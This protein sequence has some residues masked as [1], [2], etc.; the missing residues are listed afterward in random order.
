MTII[1]VEEVNNTTEELIVAGMITSTP[2]L[3]WVKDKFNPQYIQNE[4]VKLLTDLILEHF[5]LHGEAPNNSIRE[6]FASIEDHIDAEDVTITKRLLKKISSTYGEREISFEV[7]SDTT[8]DYFEVRSMDVLV[9]KIAGLSKRGKVDEAKEEVQRWVEDPKGIQLGAASPFDESFAEAILET[10]IPMFKFHNDLDVI[11]PHQTKNKLYTFLGGTK[12]GKSQWLGWVGV[13]ALSNGLKVLIWEYELTQIEFLHRMLSVITGKG[14]KGGPDSTEVT[15][16]ISIFDCLKNRTGDCINPDRPNQDPL[17]NF[18][19]YEDDTWIPCTACR[20]TDLFSPVVWK[21]P[22]VK[23]VINTVSELKKEQTKWKRQYGD[24]LR[25]FNRDPGSQNVKD[26]KNE[27][28]R[29]RVSEGFVPD[30]IVIDAADNILPSKSY[31]DKR[32]EL[33]NIWSEISILAKHGYLV[34]TASQTN[35]S[36]W[37]KEWITTEM[38]GEDASKLMICDG[39]ILINQYSSPGVINEYYWNTQR[40]RPAFFRGQKLPSYDVKVLHDF[41][42]YIACIDCQKYR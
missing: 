20:G 26:L 21:E 13:E 8:T 42:R 40:L 32:H 39:T 18:S 11:F 23:S 7:L 16:G 28:A 38:I 31:A 15:T 41:S 14:I 1:K 35:R 22:Y 17:D 6:L 3:A 27:L 4:Q 2:Y 30:M 12:S 33:N 36:G 29:L 10:Q 25:I 19:L 24:N 9:T 34:W 5:E 37:N